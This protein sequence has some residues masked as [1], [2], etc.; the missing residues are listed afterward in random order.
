MTGNKAMKLF[1]LL[2]GLA[3]ML[4]YK[5]KFYITLGVTSPRYSSHVVTVTSPDVTS[6]GVISH[7]VT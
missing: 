2:V 3:G 1:L 4:I 5:R 7:G 6:P